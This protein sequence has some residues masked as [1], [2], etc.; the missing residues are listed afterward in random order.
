M[1]EPDSE[2]AEAVR[3]AYERYS[4]GQYTDRD[5]ARWLNEQGYRTRR[6]RLWTKDA[7]RDMLQNEFY[8]GMVKYK[9]GAV[10]RAASAD[11]HAGVV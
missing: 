2:T 10:P 8:L 11:H 5:I 7:A 4:T 6:G 1:A 3:E 9:G